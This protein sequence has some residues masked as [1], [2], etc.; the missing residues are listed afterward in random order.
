MYI[1]RFLALHCTN[2]LEKLSKTDQTFSATSPNTQKNNASFPDKKEKLEKQFLQ[3][4]D[5]FYF[6]N[7]P[8]FYFIFQIK[9]TFFCEQKKRKSFS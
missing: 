4:T 3:T 5:F 8:N 2:V 9:K 7:F 1:F 6:R